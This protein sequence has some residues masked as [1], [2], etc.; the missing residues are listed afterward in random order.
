MMASAPSAPAA[1]LPLDALLA[2]ARAAWGGGRRDEAIGQWRLAAASFPASNA[3]YVNLAGALGAGT[4]T[5]GWVHRAA[6]LLGAGDPKIV[7]NL[8]VLAERRGESDRARRLIM[9]ALILDPGQV[10]AVGVLVKLD[11][12][13]DAGLAVRWL[14]RSAVTA[15]ST[16]RSWLD[17]LS[18]VIHAGQETAGAGYVDRVPIPAEAWPDELL[19]SAVHVYFAAARHAD[20]LPLVTMLAARDPESTRPRKMRA[21]IFRRL[22]DLKA[23][24]REARRSVLLSP[25]AFGGLRHLGGELARNDEFGPAVLQF[26]RALLVDP[27]RR[28]EILENF[29]ATLVKTD[30]TEEADRVV[31]E[32]LVNRPDRGGGYLNQSILAFQVADLRRAAELAERAVMA[33]P[34][35]PDALY[36]LGMLRRHQAR[37]PE[38]RRLLTEATSLDDK[39]PYRFVH[40]MLELGGGDPEEG[41]QRYEVRW[42]IPKFSSSRLLGRT[43]TLAL[44]VWTGEPLPEATLGVWGEQGIG[45]E[46]WFAS[47]LGWAVERVGHTVLEISPSLVSLM[48]RSYPGVDVRARGE[49]ATDRALAGAQMQVPMGGIMR[50]FGAASRPVP[51]GYLRAD[52]A[53][54]ARLRQRYTAGREGVRVVG[55]SWRSVKPVRGRSFEAP[56]EDWRAVF[57]LENTVF[58]SLQ[59]GDV[60]ADAR[61]VKERFGAEL[62]VDP[63]I[64]AYDD[65]D[66]FAAQVAATDAV[67]SIGNSTVAMA[68]ALGKPAYVAAR[69]IQDDW[70]YRP[71]SELTRWLPTAHCAWQTDPR[72]WSTPLAALVDRLRRAG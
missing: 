10:T 44:P 51:T 67:I 37:V 23:A 48:E 72:D 12:R 43:P 22:G 42:E 28:P 27:G 32:A 55:M 26:R 45:D 60:A 19:W 35:L 18:A 59:Y 38:A 2:S 16:A 65:L 66:G 52:P 7:R 13:S 68:H 49:A 53:R 54:V 9:Q 25:G 4:P 1:D 8:A 34:K 69:I 62:I 3:P 14:A 30:A 70:R 21:V 6:G 29:G 20:A 31:R 58:V 47:Y 24:A 46:L 40:A 64:D 15:P 41:L 17:L 11:G 36:H 63:E 57:G 33:A 61:L 56:L 39:P 50:P 5:P 71:G